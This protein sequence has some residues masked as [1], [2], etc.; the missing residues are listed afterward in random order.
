MRVPFAETSA[1]EDLE[2]ALA[3]LAVWWVLGLEQLVWLPIGLLACA[4]LLGSS[5]PTRIT[6]LAGGALLLVVAQLFSA[7]FVAE[8]E[9][10]ITL[11]RNLL[12]YTAIGVWLYALTNA[13]RSLTDAHRLVRGLALGMSSAAAVGMLGIV[14]IWR[15]TH[16]SP[17]AL[18]LPSS[19]I[20]T[21]FGSQFVGRSTGALAWFV[22]FGEYYRV[23]SFFLF[24]TFY[25]IAL[26]ATVPALV[27]LFRS[28]E[29]R[30]H[31]IGWSISL[32]VVLTNLV[33]TTGRMAVI[34]LVVGAL[35]FA[36]MR[37]RAL[38]VTIILLSSITALS[39]ANSESARARVSTIVQASA[40]ARGS[41]SVQGRG[42]VYRATLEG[43]R[44][45]PFFGWG[46]ERDVVGLKYPAGSH[47]NYLGTLYRLGLFGLLALLY[48]L[49]AAWRGTT[50]R[51]LVG[52]QKLFVQCSRWALACLLI[53]GLTD[54]L[55]LDIAALVV[56]WTA[57]GVGYA[58]VHH[59][60]VAR[61]EQVL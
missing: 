6:P 58:V 56:A 9:R 1:L 15:P 19:L 44:E 37:S 26:V 38:I 17:L 25:S 10:S 28:A 12:A 35:Y 14:G 50:T 3:G 59:Q 47:S 30:R 31:R 36:A 23:E 48:L 53:I 43:I 5:R 24:A 41:G 18:V 13:V 39:L 42:A 55:D 60:V 61:G 20:E 16:S 57:I 34:A 21:T 29:R 49:I 32:F 27:W 8:S 7:A 52:E 40:Y 11:A 45:R 33:Y 51:S 4:K 22:G 46:T 54:S 2:L